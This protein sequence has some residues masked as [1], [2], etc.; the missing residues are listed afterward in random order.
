M[1]R[2]KNLRLNIILKMLR[3][4]LEEHKEIEKIRLPCNKS[5]C[6]RGTL[7]KLTKNRSA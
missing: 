3:E 1:L 5:S 7:N 2:L 6:C 4:E